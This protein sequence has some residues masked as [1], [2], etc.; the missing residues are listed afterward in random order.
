MKKK[1]ITVP[2][3][4]VLRKLIKESRDELMG[5]EFNLEEVQDIVA[6]DFQDHG[7]RA[8]ERRQ[9]AIDDL[10]EDFGGDEEDLDE[11]D[12]EDLDEAGD[13]DSSLKESR[14]RRTKHVNAS[15]LRV[16]IREELIKERM[17]SRA[18]SAANK[19]LD[20]RGG[21]RKIGVAGESIESAAEKLAD[22]LGDDLGQEH[23]KAV[24]WW[25]KGNPLVRLRNGQITEK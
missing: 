24:Q 5:I 11:A 13:D 23:V 15:R 17:G 25:V 2:F 16:I 4:S 1:E 22:V 10:Y 20:I 14:S 12:E 18:A 21:D 3:R 8:N 19:I 6:H 7:T 9:R